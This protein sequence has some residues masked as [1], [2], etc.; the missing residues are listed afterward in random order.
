MS[1]PKFSQGSTRAGEG[2]FLSPERWDR[3]EA[4]TT[5]VCV[6]RSL[7]YYKLY[8]SSH[9]EHVH[10]G[11]QLHVDCIEIP[12]FSGGED[13]KIPC[14]RRTTELKNKVVQ[15]GSLHLPK[16]I[17]EETLD[18]PMAAVHAM[19]TQQTVSYFSGHPFSPQ[20]HEAARSASHKSNA[21]AI[22]QQGYPVLEVTHLNHFSRF[23]SSGMFSCQINI[24]SSRAW[25]P[26]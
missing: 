12:D 4:F 20:D 18:I 9:C 5:S 21:S 8:L 10:G 19:D 24:C 23:C 17:S 2:G 15:A 1:P 13:Q 11:C 16:R 3:S 6:C 22:S 7:S 26:K 25:L 14:I